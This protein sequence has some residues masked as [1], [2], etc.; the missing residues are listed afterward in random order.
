[1]PGTIMLPSMGRHILFR[2]PR[3]GL[4]VQAWLEDA[5]EK[6]TGESYQSIDCPACTLVH[7]IHRGSGRLLGEKED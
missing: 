3:T 1:M 4:K 2:C 5:P 7:F 6:A